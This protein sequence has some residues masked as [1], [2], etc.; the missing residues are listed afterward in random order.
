[1]AGYVAV[2]LGLA[3]LLLCL[4]VLGPVIAPTA[5]SLLGINVDTTALTLYFFGFAT[6]YNSI[7]L[8]T[9]ALY[10][11]KK[12]SAEGISESHLFTLMI[13]CR[14][15]E[16]VVARTVRSIMAL[17]YPRDKFEVLVIN[18]GS[19]DATGQIVR[20]LKAEYPNLSLFEI[21]P[22]VGGRGK[23]AALNAGFEHLQMTSGFRDSGDKWVVGVFDADGVPDAEILTKA[24]FKFLNPRVGAVQALVRIIDAK[25]SILTTLQDIEFVT[26]AKVTQFARSIFGGAVALGGNGQFIRS[27][28]LESIRLPSGEYWRNGALTEDLDLGTRA[29]LMGWGNDFLSTVA[30]YQHG[31]TTFSALY[32]QRT[33]WSWGALQCFRTY[34]LTLSP[35]RYPISLVKKV[36]LMY[37]LSAAILP[38]IILAVWA[39]SILAVLG[40]LVAHNPFPSYF[41]IAN[42]ISFFPLIGYGLWSVR[43]EYDARMMIPLLVL[44]NAYTYHW[45]VCTAAAMARMARGEKPR[46]V[47]TRKTAASPEEPPIPSSTLPAQT[48]GR[49]DV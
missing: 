49:L 27:T 33:R 39:L 19:T 9:I 11:K 40:I 44:T 48:S 41:M 42:S 30:V 6:I 10:D 18:D 17:D 8:S 45:V 46:W 1:M 21:D 23:S 29:L 28:T 36:D 24:S 4:S 26:F 31:V 14:N 38:P 32:K 35:F 2:G 7:L 47:V 12:H 3:M 22:A 34:A 43:K 5:H 25:R 20:K 16:A 37:Y 13:P 15:E